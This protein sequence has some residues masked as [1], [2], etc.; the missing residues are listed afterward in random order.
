MYRIDD[1]RLWSTIDL[2][3]RVLLKGRDE[4]V[5]IVEQIEFQASSLFCKC[6]LY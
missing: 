6:N 2:K 3:Y 5:Y 1:I 4:S